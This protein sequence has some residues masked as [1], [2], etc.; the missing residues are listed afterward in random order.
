MVRWRSNG[1]YPFAHLRDE[2]DRLVGDFFGRGG[3]SRAAAGMG[4]HPGISGRQ[5]V[6]RRG[7]FVR[8]GRTA[9]R[10]E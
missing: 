5:R 10:E 4:C 9:R 8:R 3:G 6:G 1:G 2:V 7:T